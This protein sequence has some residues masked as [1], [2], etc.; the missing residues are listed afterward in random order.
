MED[1]KDDPELSKDRNQGA[2]GDGSSAESVDLKDDAV[3][4]RST[5]KLLVDQSCEEGRVGIL[6]QGDCV[7]HPEMEVVHVNKKRNRD[8]CLNVRDR[9]RR[10]SLNQA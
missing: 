6:N 8:K 10:A 5:Q 9:Q 7:N 3:P 1:P 4:F 2:E